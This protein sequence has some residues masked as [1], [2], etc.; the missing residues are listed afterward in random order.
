VP[1]YRYATDETPELMPLPTLLA[2]RLAQ[3]ANEVP[4]S[5]LLPGRS[6]TG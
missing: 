4:R 6:R 1:A 5:G 3:Q 2:Q